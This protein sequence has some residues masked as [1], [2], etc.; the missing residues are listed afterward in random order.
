VEAFLQRYQVDRKQ[1]RRVADTAL[2][3][4]TQLH[5]ECADP[6]DPDRRFL[7]WAALLHEI[8]LSVAHSSYHKHTAY[9]LANAD[10]PGF[11]RM[12]Q[13]RL[14]RLDLAHRGKLERVQSIAPDSADW[15]LILCLRLAVIVHRARDARAP[16]GLAVEQDKRGHVLH[17][18]ADW[19]NSLPLTAAALQEEEQQWSRLGRNLRLKINRQQTPMEAG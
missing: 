3:L 14:A 6:E 17:A 7:E 19:L 13:G 18:A 8:G 2:A 9:I 4:L 11:S 1:A 5:P 10:M 16:V 12:D 15:D